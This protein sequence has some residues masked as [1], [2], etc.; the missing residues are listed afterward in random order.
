MR[1]D[2]GFTLIEMVLVLLLLSVFLGLAVPN[3]R[4]SFEQI[5][6]KTTVR[7]LAEVMRY[8]QSEAVTTGDQLKL[9]FNPEFSKYW[10]TRVK[11]TDHDERIK[12]PLGDIFVLPDD[13]KITA[14]ED[15]INFY[16]D[17]TIDKQELSGC[18]QNRC[19]II[20]TQ[21]QRGKVLVYDQE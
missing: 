11:D 2:H 15:V 12:T 3:F 16:P 17:G 20:S 21:A 19:L 5:E 4:K 1:R 14:P 13:F 10:L 18:H 8:A 7:H 6:L 9:E